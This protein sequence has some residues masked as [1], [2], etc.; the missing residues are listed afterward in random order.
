MSLLILFDAD[1]ATSIAAINV[2]D[3]NVLT[4]RL[5]R[6]EFDDEVVVNDNYNDVNNYSINV[7]SGSGD[8][9]V[10]GVLPINTDTSLDLILITDPMTPDTR[11]E[12]SIDSL[13]TRDGLDFSVL[14]E[15][16]ARVT[17]GDS[18]LRSIPQHYDRRSTSNLHKILMA[19]SSEDDLIGG[20]RSEDI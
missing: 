9:R 12:V 19:M 1:G 18:I 20:S 6:I 8:V 2:V 7:V 13:Q 17:K 16:V 5:V 14:G 10:V 11:Y 3:I 4:K 15:Y